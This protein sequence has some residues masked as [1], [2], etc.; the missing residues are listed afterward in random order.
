MLFRSR[1][2]GDV[3][4][5]FKLYKNP[6]RSVLKKPSPLLVTHVVAG[7]ESD[8][9][10]VLQ[11]RAFGP[12]ERACSLGGVV[13]HIPVAPGVQTQPAK[14][15]RHMRPFG[16]G[17]SYKVIQACVLR[18]PKGPPLGLILGRAVPVAIQPLPSTK[19]HCFELKSIF[20]FYDLDFLVF[21]SV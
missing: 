10:V 13:A 2:S 20:K 21:F 18:P 1:D 15:V 17:L 16:H 12:W 19:G 7:D 11:A 9:F 14:T 5:G 3:W 8:Q 4:G 6:L